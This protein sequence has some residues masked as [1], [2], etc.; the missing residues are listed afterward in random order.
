MDIC[1]IVSRPRCY[2]PL[3]WRHILFTE[4]REWWCYSGH[5]L[6]IASLVHLLGFLIVFGANSNKVSS[7]WI[8]LLLL[9]LLLFIIIIIIEEEKE[10]RLLNAVERV[11]SRLPIPSKWDGSLEATVLSTSLGTFSLSYCIFIPYTFSGLPLTTT[12]YWLVAC[13][14]T[15]QPQLL[16][17]IILICYLPR[18]GG[19]GLLCYSSSL[20]G[21]TNVF[22]FFCF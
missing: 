22:L 20:N 19:I 21:S 5:L 4:E 6:L 3:V 10:V 15:I 9:L 16:G 1:L 18:S 14:L 12:S 2:R 13:F 8:I 17:S 11:W 7:L